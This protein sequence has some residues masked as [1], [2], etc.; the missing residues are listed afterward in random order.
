MF[1]F[2]VRWACGCR[3]IEVVLVVCITALAEAKH[4]REQCCCGC[5]GIADVMHGKNGCGTHVSQAAVAVGNALSSFVAASR[6]Q[7]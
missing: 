3:T 2:A 6:G 4:D 7:C 1:R 5:L